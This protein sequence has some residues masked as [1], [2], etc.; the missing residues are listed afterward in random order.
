MDF[1]DSLSSLTT[2]P[3]DAVPPLASMGT[4]HARS[5]LTQEQAMLMHKMDAAKEKHSN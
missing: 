2:A 1:G 3:G 5:V 4:R